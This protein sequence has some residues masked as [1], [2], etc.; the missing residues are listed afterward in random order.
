[1]PIINTVW[2]DI[3]IFPISRYLAA[4]LFRT[5]IVDQGFFFR[6]TMFEMKSCSKDNNLIGSVANQV[7]GLKRQQQMALVS[8]IINE[9][10]WN[11]LALSSNT[12]G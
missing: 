4:S 3:S 6:S 2:S 9:M 7:P 1:M 12:S 8:L 5:K 10:Q 11:S